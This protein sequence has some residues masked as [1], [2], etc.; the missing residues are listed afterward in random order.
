M[1]YLVLRAES[2]M[3]RLYVCTEDESVPADTVCWCIEPQQLNRAVARVKKFWL[4][5]S[6]YENGA[7]LVIEQ[8]EAV[9]HLR[10]VLGPSLEEQIEVKEAARK[11][12]RVSG[13]LFLFTT[14][15][16]LVVSAFW[17]GVSTLLL[18]FLIPV[19]IMLLGRMFK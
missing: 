14:V 17:I 7:L 11:V 19:I 3:C 8:G 18:I 15:C 5:G 1:S 2:S 9:E 16:S 4:S 13:G 6:M 10:A 12:D